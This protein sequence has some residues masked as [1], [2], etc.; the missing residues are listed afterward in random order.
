[1]AA[2]ADQLWPTYVH[3]LTLDMTVFSTAF[4]NR[5]HGQIALFHACPITTI[6]ELHL[7]EC[8]SFKRNDPLSYCLSGSI[9]YR[10]IL[11][12]VD[13]QKAK[14]SLLQLLTTMNS[15]TIMNGETLR[16]GKMISKE[17]DQ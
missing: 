16:N 9:T 17:T 7:Y 10:T 12:I 6:G 4:P 15:H 11:F 13:A 2:A 1:M 5:L 14:G 3:T 8:Q